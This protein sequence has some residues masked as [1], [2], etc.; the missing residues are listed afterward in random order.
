MDTVLEELQARDRAI[1]R[2]V[3][4]YAASW[5]D[6]VDV[7][8]TKYAARK[9][10]AS[11]S[12]RELGPA[13]ATLIPP[14]GLPDMVALIPLGE[15]L[16]RRYLDRYGLYIHDAGLRYQIRLRATHAGFPGLPGSGRIK[17]ICPIARRWR[18]GSGAA[19]P[20]LPLPG[21]AA[22][23]SEPDLLTEWRGPATLLE[24][25]PPIPLELPLGWNPGSNGAAPGLRRILHRPFADLMA[26][27]RS[28]RT[29][30]DLA[31]A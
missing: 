23:A 16:G 7:G 3:E 25:G 8:L 11:A 2:L 30:A 24:L 1:S 14:L 4:D 19:V 17:V 29:L 6:L 31:K 22:I 5:S 13:E 15:D 12:P 21:A 20:A 28:G 9:E 10:V 27:A 26:A 18:I